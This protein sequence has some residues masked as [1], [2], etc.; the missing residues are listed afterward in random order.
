[1]N[2]QQSSA[3]TIYGFLEEL[4]SKSKKILLISSL[5]PLLILSVFIG[6]T[7][8]VFLLF[9]SSFQGIGD[10]L[11]FSASF[12]FLIFII[13]F[14]PSIF[15][16]I[17]IYLSFKIFLLTKIQQ[18]FPNM[19][20]SLDSLFLNISLLCGIILGLMAARH[21]LIFIDFQSFFKIGLSNI[22]EIVKI[23]LI[24]FLLF[25][26]FPM[27]LFTYYAYR[28]PDN[29]VVALL[30]PRDINLSNEKEKLAYDIF[31]NIRIAFG[32]APNEVKLKVL[33]WDNINAMVVSSKNSNT[34]FITKK[35][36]ETLDYHELE[37]IFAHEFSH[38]KN[39]DSYYLSTISIAGQFS[40][41]LSWF[42]MTIVP[43]VII[44]SKRQTKE[45]KKERGVNFLDLIDY[46]IAAISFIVGF[47]FTIIT[48]KIFN[49]LISSLSKDRERIADSTAVLTTKY[50]PG[51]LSLLVKVGKEDTSKFIKEMNFPTSFQALLFD[52][53]FETHPK[54]WERIE[55]ISQYTNTPLPN[56]YHEFKQLNI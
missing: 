28:K 24:I 16:S 8:L 22:L 5:F 33:E 37:S 27:Y 23:T 54:I 43:S 21:L 19:Y 51:F 46:I 26:I 55:Y 18:K 25:Y 56:E 20:R 40:V 53:E 50:P 2:S 11:F 48:P 36:I 17:F 13:I 10:I 52:Y 42:L 6:L 9:F 14:F 47:T 44:S 15:L 38:I 31:D 7:I 41:I 49:K 3:T 34:V 35:A 30:N 12:F 32:I 1:M 45:R 4:K 39:Q 29:V